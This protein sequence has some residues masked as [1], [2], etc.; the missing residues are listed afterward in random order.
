MGFLHAFP[1]PKLQADGSFCFS[2]SNMVWVWGL[3]AGD[4][5]AFS[6]LR[7]L[8]QLLLRLGRAGLPSFFWVLGIVGFLLLWFGLLCFASGWLSSGSG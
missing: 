3:S 2:S 6:W 7:L 4:A 1:S 8:Y 5:I